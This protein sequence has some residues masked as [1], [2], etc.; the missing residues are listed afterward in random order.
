MANDISAF[1]LQVQVKASNTFPAGFTVTEFADD[2]DPFDIP[3]LTILESAMGMNGDL[4]TWS[5]ANP[6]IIN[7]AVIPGS[8]DDR[9]LAAL[10]EQNRVG[11][12]KN[13]ARDVI[14]MTGIYP[15]ERTITLSNGKISAGMPGEGVASA[16][17]MKSKVY[18]FVFENM[19][20]T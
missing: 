15:S 9:N 7:I 3:S 6:L 1:G 16:G 20:R 18:S 8:D 13:G 19:T 17:R 11:K 14:T 12:G 2:S 10:F 4:V 5:K